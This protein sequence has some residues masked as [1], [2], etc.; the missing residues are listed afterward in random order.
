ML[1]DSPI[2]T[3]AKIDKAMRLNPAAAKRLCA[4][5]IATA[6]TPYDIF[7]ACNRERA[8]ELALRRHRINLMQHGRR[9]DTE[10]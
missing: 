4:F 3:P 5:V 6:Y 7:C 1:T 9:K 8:Y 2:V 10:L